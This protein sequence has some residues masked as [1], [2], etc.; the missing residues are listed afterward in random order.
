MTADG[1]EIV[2]WPSRSA[3]PTAKHYEEQM[4]PLILS[5]REETLQFPP[6]LLI[7]AFFLDKAESSGDPTDVRIDR[8]RGGSLTEEQQN[9]RCLR[10]DTRQFHQ[11]LPSFFDITDQQPVYVTFIPFEDG[12]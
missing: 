12:L 3:E 11:S 6:H 1:T 5:T 8:E 10:S 4:C 9:V 2:A 7:T